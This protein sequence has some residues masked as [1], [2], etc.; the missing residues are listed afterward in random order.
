MG[1]QPRG[2]RFM[3]R[4]KRPKLVVGAF[5]VLSVAGL[6]F[7]S[8]VLSPYARAFERSTQDLLGT[9]RKVYDNASPEYQKSAMSPGPSTTRKNVVEARV[10]RRSTTTLLGLARS[11]CCDKSRTS[12]LERERDSQ[13]VMGLRH[14]S[15]IPRPSGVSGAWGISTDGECG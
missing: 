6:G 8:S 2:V 11:A 9:V 15:L 3:S 7:W 1:R 13:V 14:F 10:S 5:V 12:T 4:L